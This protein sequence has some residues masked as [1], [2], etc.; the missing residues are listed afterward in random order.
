MTRG[1][2]DFRP[3]TVD[4]YFAPGADITWRIDV[5]DTG[6]TVGTVAVTIDGVT[7][8][9]STA[10]S[11][12]NH[13][14]VDIAL[15][16]TQTTAIGEK[17]VSWQLSNTTTGVTI[18]WV[19]GTLMG[20][21]P[22]NRL[23]SNGTTQVV[24]SVGTATVT[25]LVGAS[26]VAALAAHEADT[27]NIH[28]I[29]DTSVLAT[30]TSVATA[31]STHA[32]AADPHGD[33]SYADGLA[34]GLQPLD[35]DLTAIAALATTAYGRALLALADAAALRTAGGLGTIS[36]Q[37]A[38]S[39]AIT[40]GSVT[41]ITDITV[42]DGGTGAST[43]A[44]ARTNL[45]LVIGSDV[46]AYS[47]VLAGTTASYTTAEASKLAG[48][49]AGATADQTAAE[50]LAALL[51]VDGAGSSLDADLLDG[52]SSAYY[53]T[54]ASLS[55]Y[56]P[57][58]SDLTALAA[59]TTTTYG[60]AL[61]ELANAAALRT[62]AGLVIGTDVQAYDGELAA[63]AGLTS[64][65]DSLP[66]FT[67]SGTAALATF[68]AAGR[69]LVDD[70]DAAAQRTTL[71]LG[72]I[73]TQAANSVSVSGGTITG[74][75]DLTV[76]D[77]GTGASDAATARTNLIVPEGANVGT[78]N[79][80]VG[81]G[82]LASRTSGDYNTAVG[83]NVQTALTTG[84]ENTGMGYNAQLGLTTGA[85]NFGLGRS[86]Q[87]SLTTGGQNLG[88]G[89]YAQFTLSTGSDNTSIGVLSQAAGSAGMTG[90][91]NVAIGRGAQYNMTTG[92]ANVAVGNYAGNTTTTA[93]GQTC[94]GHDSGDTAAQSWNV[95]AVGLSA[96]VSGDYSTALGA[97]TSATGS[98]SVAIGT[99]SSGTGASTSV[100]NE[101][102]LGTSSHT[103]NV[104]G[105]LNFTGTTASTVGAAGGASALPAT[106]TGYV[107][108]S[109][110]GTNYK[111]PYYAT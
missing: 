19:G 40:G 47:S 82:T 89:G 16:D 78:T 43:A 96:R 24:T 35:S 81:S 58:D 7:P 72:T 28:G 59:L 93:H 12:T 42:A 88:V 53:A 17:A 98:G 63:L 83:Y 74:I 48:I 55:G 57:L 5:N 25:S 45:G 101:I 50:I 108:I 31:V 30:A 11:T 79:L 65:A 51:T 8:S 20:S 69:A 27:T 54:A 39:V 33:R 34:A 97:S 14:I 77:G 85:N 6:I 4:V 61:L 10:A 86:A 73:A 95:T 23:S 32:G 109:I 13:L 60:R 107:V 66:Y 41:G 9:V 52:Q 70:A 99:N 64:A 100:A 102:K 49:E 44:N 26:S 87:Q 2:L 111:L 68:T 29:A 94:L 21:P 92:V 91:D 36:T 56:Q 104:P 46:Q 18:I 75:T 110:G 90:T 3:A 80:R 1:S 103:V 71:G 38:N 84:T 105:T 67:G 22:G 76:A 37:A 62:A 106:P 15:S